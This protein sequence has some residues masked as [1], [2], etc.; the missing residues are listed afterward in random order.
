MPASAS[1]EIT[2]S[3]S[4]TRVSTPNRS[5]THTAHRN[6]ITATAAAHPFQ[7]R[8]TRKDFFSSISAAK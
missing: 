3:G 7:A 2:R 8:S 1:M 5:K 4:G 6:A